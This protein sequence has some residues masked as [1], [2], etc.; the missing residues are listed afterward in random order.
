MTVTGKTF[1][2]AHKHDDVV[3]FN[4]SIGAKDKEG[5]WHNIRFNVFFDTDNFNRDALNKANDGQC[6]ELDVKEGSF[7]VNAK[8]YLCL[9]VKNG[10]LSLAK[11]KTKSSDNVNI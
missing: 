1:I 6:Y 8:D 4:G 5:T 7:L 2:W 11:K 9:F 3:L 10:T